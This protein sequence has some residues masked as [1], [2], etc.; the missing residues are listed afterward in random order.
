[1]SDNNLDKDTIAAVATPVGQAGIGIVRLSGPIAH[2]IAKKVFKPKRPLEEFQSH[3]LY[4]G[5]L[6]DPSSEQMV[7][8]V[9]LSFMK[10]PHTYTTE[11]VVE[12][13]S[14]SGYLLLS[15][16]LQIVL[17]EGARLA[18][19]G[20]FTFRAFV[21]GRIDLTQAEAI[22]DLI[23]SKSR[24]GL[25]L[26]SQQIKGAFRTEIE[27]LREKIVEILAYTEVAIDFPEEDYTDMPSTEMAQRI[28]KDVLGPIEDIMAGHEK[29]RI[30]MDGIKTVIVGSVNVGKSSLM[31]RL[32]NEERAIVTP[33][34]GTTRDI[35]ESSIHI[36]GIPILLMDT[37]GFREVQ[38]EAERI[39][40]RLA[41]ER[42]ADADLSLIVLD[43]SRPLTQNDFDI[44]TKADKSRSLI[45]LN[46]IDLT[47]GVSQKDLDRALD[48]MSVVRISALTGEGMDD[49]HKA[50]RDHVLGGHMDPMSSGLAPN[51][52]HRH[53]LA[54]AS[55]YFR[56]AFHNINQGLPLE[57]IAVDLNS[58]LEALGDIIGETTNED[59]IE[60]IFS[61]FCVGK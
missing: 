29:R 20:E 24:I 38:G 7:D 14:H 8:E 51:L 34:P 28:L 60:K 43:Q 21:N 10:A 17:R 6:I 46:K 11:D 39:G 27:G 40:I 9:L 16:I 57:V 55:K 32:L 18:N 58:G 23:N 56:G 42:M 45:L 36:E 59:V 3:K 44:L 22:M 25:R 26:A 33:I 61:D 4:L 15:M 19:P 54:D 53:A 30:W 48:G 2:Q 41:K 1:M 47:S 13:N 31:N 5:H 49:L 35:I 50:I 12:I 52:R 37:A